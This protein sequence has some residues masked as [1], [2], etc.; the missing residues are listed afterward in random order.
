[1]GEVATRKYRGP[2][3]TGHTF[4]PMEAVM[5]YTEAIQGEFRDE[6]KQAH[7]RCEKKGPGLAT[8]Y[9]FRAQPRK[10]AL[11]LP[12][13]GTPMARISGGRPAR[14]G[15]I[16]SSTIGGWWDDPL[17]QSLEDEPKKTRGLPPACL[18]NNVGTS[19]TSSDIGRYWHDDG[20][21]YNDLHTEAARLKNGAKR[22]YHEATVSQFALESL[23][24]EHRL[25]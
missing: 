8:A 7:G 5:A 9:D 18:G 15:T 23:P 6:Y 20:L 21:S 16:S 19:T 13:A 10:E 4:F 17:F 25:L 12:L 3:C 11:P 22:I 24:I 14:K 1:M 2:F